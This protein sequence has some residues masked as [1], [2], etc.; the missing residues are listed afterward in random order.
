M[1][2]LTLILCLL[3]CVLFRAQIQDSVRLR[4]ETRFLYNGYWEKSIRQKKTAKILSYTSGGLIVSGIVVGKIVSDNE[5]EGLLKGLK[6]AVIGGSII[7]VGVLTGLASVPFW[8]SSSK[9]TGRAE[10]LKNK[11]SIYPVFQ[12]NQFNQEKYVGMGL[13]IAFR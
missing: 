12:Q 4:E 8:A 2:K 6:G 13:C 1:K 5:K 9:N 3:F 10:K 11:I 7:A